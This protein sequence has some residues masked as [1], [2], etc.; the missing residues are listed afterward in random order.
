MSHNNQSKN[1]K[2]TSQNPT[3]HGYSHG[4]RLRV[5][6]DIENGLL[7]ANQAS[8]K[9]HVSLRSIQRWMDKF[10]NQD[11]ILRELGGKSPKQEI[12]ELMKKLEKLE[13]EKDIL[14][15]ALEIVEEEYGVDARKK[16]LPE[17]M[18]N[19]LKNLKKE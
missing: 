6:A 18:R 15:I 14:E 10:G 13:M 11:K 8:K 4:F 12:K 5:L 19:T 16:L 7:S 2:P 1:Q 17:S 3:Y 9:Y